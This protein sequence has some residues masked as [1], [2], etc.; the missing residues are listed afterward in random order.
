MDAMEQS[1][2][3]PPAFY[4]G[5]HD[6]NRGTTVSE[7]LMDRARIIGYDMITTPITNVSF[8]DHVQ[9]LLDGHRQ[10]GHSS[11]DL[12]AMPLVPS[13]G[14]EFTDLSP[15]SSTA[16]MIAQLSPWADVT[17]A[18]ELVAHISR[19]VIRIEIAYAA[20]CGIGNVILPPLYRHHNKPPTVRAIS[21]FADVVS[22]TLGIGPYLQILVPFPMDDQKLADEDVLTYELEGHLEKGISANEDDGRS[23]MD[24]MSPWD[25]WDHVRTTCNHASKLA[26]AL[27]IPRLLPSDHLQSRW[28]SEPLRILSLSS[29]SFASNPN[30]HPVLSKAHQAMLIKYM[31]LQQAPWLLLSGPSEL[32]SPNSLSSAEPTPAEAAHMPPATPS[33][34]P[35]LA[36]LRYLQRTQPPLPPLARFAQGYQDF[37]QSPLQPLTDNL[38]SITYEV[39]EKDPIKYAWYEQAT[40]LAL[41][42]LHEA[43]R[44]PIVVAVVGA[45][46]GPLMTRALKASGTTGIPI[47][48]YAVEKNPNAFV[49]LQ[50]R[51]ATDSLWGGKVQII[52]TDMRSWAGPIDQQ[53]RSAKVDILISELL[54]SFADNELSPECLDGVQHHLDP[55]HGVSI[56][57]SYT[58]WITPVASPRIHADLLHRPGDPNKWVLPYVTMLHQFSFLSHTD[59]PLAPTPAG[60][61][62]FEPSIQQCWEFSHPVP[63]SILEQSALRR[64]G[65]QLAPGL[66]GSD[67][68]NEHNVRSCH[69]NF[70]VGEVSRGVC[71]GLAGYFETVLYRSRDGS[72]IVELST[73]PN[74][75]EKSKDMISWFPIFFPLKTPLHVPDGSEVRVDMHRNTDDRKVWY[76][77]Q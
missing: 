48:P 58:A 55:Q 59:K 11:Q 27:S 31:R 15:D 35:R 53:G 13:L 20:F 2:P 70:P 22:Q 34:V 67:G 71:H 36:Y 6:V 10:T 61:L 75:E 66:S 23:K 52:K 32:P 77:W 9:K 63:R 25:A 16:A 3:P 74:T 42:D 41:K 4:I 8:R 62:S 5:H 50:R 56:P 60:L 30:H 46:R 76:T 17:S 37:L 64:R 72:Q 24:S 14:P 47:L 39:F 7:A 38:E 51:N 19:Q 69:L 26:V 68:W 54:G 45:G 57:Q 12:S 43:L 18:D 65:G 73:N 1:G 21:A 44:R 40:A 33:Q 49:L 28:Y 29:S